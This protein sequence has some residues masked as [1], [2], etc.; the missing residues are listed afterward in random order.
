MAEMISGYA[1]VF[2][3]DTVIGNEFRERIDPKAFDRTLRESPDVVALLDHDTG[4]VLG[5]TAA[6]TLK[7]RPD[8]IGLRFS[9]KI[10]ETTPE[11][12]SA[13]GT[14]RRGDVRGMSFGFRVRV[15]EWLDG[16]HRL[17]LRVIK[18]CDLFEIT[19]TAFPAYAT[20]SAAV[21]PDNQRNGKRRVD[22]KRRAEAA[23]L[24]RGLL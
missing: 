24:A 22:S 7:L 12:Q 19:A 15:E 8:R 16:G 21:V 1:A 17:P 23:M 10:D 5:R 18:D 6:G 13:L 3:Q 11:G 4:R 20:T 9:L 2:G 14:I